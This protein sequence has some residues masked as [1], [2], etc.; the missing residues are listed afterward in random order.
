MWPDFFNLS[1]NENV[2]RTKILLI[3]IA[4]VLFACSDDEK[5][6]VFAN[7]VGVWK[8]DYSEIRATYSGI[9]VYDETDETFDVTLEFK[10]DG[11]VLFSQGAG[12]AVTTGTYAVNGDRLTTNINLLSYGT[13]GE[14]TFEI[15]QLTETRLQLLLDDERELDVPDFGEVTVRIVA[16]LRFDR[17]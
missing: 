3:L 16:D 10:E 7:I 13:S 1:E 12:G 2:K 15:D 17:L 4:T 11:T 14:T 6:P 8:G 9:T 5:D